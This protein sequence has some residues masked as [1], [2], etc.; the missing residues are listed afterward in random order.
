M[1][2][3]I[4]KA[5]GHNPVALSVKP[6]FGNLFVWK[7]IYRY[8]NTY[9]VDAV[10]VGWRPTVYPGTSIVALDIPRDFPWLDPNSQQARDIERFRWFTKGYI[11]KDPEN[12]NHIIDLRYSYVPNE[13]DA[14]WSIELS[15]KANEKDHVDFVSDSRPSKDHRNI[16]WQMIVGQEPETK[17][18]Q[19][20]PR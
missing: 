8:K 12:S 13:I 14:L 19:L 20:V 10:R 6:S 1:G 5:R 15:H 4:A 9:Y 3:E 7:V 2:L 16:L 11:A 18:S 17:L